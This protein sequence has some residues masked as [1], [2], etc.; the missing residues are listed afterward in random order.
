MFFS[1]GSYSDGHCVWYD[2]CGQ[3][4]K[5]S[6]PKHIL[7]CLYEG[8]AKV[9][10]EKQIKILQEV[11]PHLLPEVFNKMFISQT[12]YELTLNS[13]MD[14]LPHYAVVSINLKTLKPTLS[15]P[16]ELDLEIVRHV[17]TTFA[18]ISAIFLVIR[19]SRSL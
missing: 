7:N 15:F 17:T 19:A 18:R 10:N 9:A 14:L 8:P 4:P 3:D 6:N 5:S 13:R 11:C 12:S 1:S 2:K 16:K